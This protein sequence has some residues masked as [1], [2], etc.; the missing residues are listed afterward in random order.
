MGEVPKDIKSIFADALEKESPKARAAYL[1]ATCG[2]DADLRTKIET[3][4]KAYEESDDVSN[5]PIVDLGL[6]PPDM[7][8]SEK[9]GT[10]IGR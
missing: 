3:L 2:D 10:V 1:D 5:E 6:K 4:L 9:L 7:T 8:F